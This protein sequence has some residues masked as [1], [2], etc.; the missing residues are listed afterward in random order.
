MTSR[1]VG[2]STTPAKRQRR[3][4]A[5]CSSDLGSERSLTPPLSPPNEQAEELCDRWPGREAECVRL[6]DLLEEVH[7]PPTGPSLPGVRR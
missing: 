1:G 4:A 5:S 2:S 6:L 3:E 7:P